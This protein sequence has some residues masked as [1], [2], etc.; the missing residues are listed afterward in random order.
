[1]YQILINGIPFKLYNRLFKNIREQQQKPLSSLENEKK[2]KKM[3]SYTFDIQ[4]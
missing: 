1:M 4:L 3:S 2:K